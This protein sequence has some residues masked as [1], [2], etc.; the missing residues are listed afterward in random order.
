[1][2]QSVAWTLLVGALAILFLVGFARWA[3]IGWTPRYEALIALGVAAAILLSPIGAREPSPRS[4]GVRLGRSPSIT[5]EGSGEE[6]APRKI[7]GLAL[8]AV[9]GS[10]LWEG[11]GDMALVR[12]VAA[13]EWADLE[14]EAREHM[15]SETFLE[16]KVRHGVFMQSLSQFEPNLLALVATL[17]SGRE[18]VIAYQPIEHPEERMLALVAK[19]AAIAPKS[20]DWLVVR[21]EAPESLRPEAKPQDLTWVPNSSPGQGSFAIGALLSI[22]AAISL[23]LAGLSKPLFGTVST[24]LWLQ[25]IYNASPFI[26]MLPLAMSAVSA[27]IKRS[28]IRLSVASLQ[29]AA[30]GVGSSRAAMILAVLALISFLGVRHVDLGFPIE[31]RIIILAAIVVA[32]MMGTF[33]WVHIRSAL[34]AIFMVTARLLGLGSSSEEQVHKPGAGALVAALTLAMVVFAGLAAAGGLGNLSVY[35]M[36]IAPTGGGGKTA[37]PL[38]FDLI[39]VAMFLGWAPGTAAKLSDLQRRALLAFVMLVVFWTVYFEAIPGMQQLN[40]LVISLYVTINGL[41]AQSVLKSAWGVRH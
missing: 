35:L 22:V 30:V 15:A 39:V 26:M 7:V 19:V 33:V 28:A 4:T 38:Y 6:I 27:H 37:I 13:K 14:A 40:P 12:Q 23:W 21:G 41:V 18:V 2:M 16:D 20:G 31:G 11:G 25:V 8:E 9:M 32:M 10:H 24:P 34:K 17:D 5:V 1:M 29:G 3:D 36:G